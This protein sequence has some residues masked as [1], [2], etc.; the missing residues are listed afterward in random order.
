[1]IM[2]SSTRGCIERARIIAALEDAKRRGPAPRARGLDAAA[3]GE[4]RRYAGGSEPN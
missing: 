3:R 4:L 1:M 2:M